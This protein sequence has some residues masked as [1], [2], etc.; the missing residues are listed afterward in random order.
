MS[1]DKEITLVGTINSS[2]TGVD[3]THPKILKRIVSQYEGIK[4][5]VSFKPL[6]Y[7]RSS[8]QNRWLWGVAY[9]RICAWYRETQ[10]ERISKEDVHSY[11]LQHV[12]EIGSKEK[13]ILGVRTVVTGIN[14]TTSAL[15]VGEYQE[16]KEKLQEYFSKRGCYIPDPKGNNTLSEYLDE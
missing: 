12:L 6:E 2:K 3:F 9:V 1:Q 16:F 14:K 5:V 10:G 8:A 11:V 7:Q 4:L 13:E 15:S